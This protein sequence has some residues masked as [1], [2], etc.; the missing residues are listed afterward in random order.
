VITAINTNQIKSWRVVLF[1][2]G[3]NGPETSWI[4]KCIQL[5]GDKG[6]VDAIHVAT[7]HVEALRGDMIYSAVSIDTWNSKEQFVS[8]LLYLDTTFS[9]TH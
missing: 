4:M 6:P 5:V 7:K 3:Q 2:C 8:Y 9:L 1:K